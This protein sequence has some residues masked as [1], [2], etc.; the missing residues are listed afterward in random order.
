MTSDSEQL[1][2]VDTGATA[3]TKMSCGASSEAIAM[4]TVLTP[5]LAVVYE[6]TGTASLKE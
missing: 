5:A 4:V 3:L 2:A 6:S 1:A